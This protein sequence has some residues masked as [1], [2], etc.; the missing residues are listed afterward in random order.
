MDKPSGLP[1]DLWV[2]I[3]Q[4]LWALYVH[5]ADR[6]GAYGRQVMYEKSGN[7]AVRP[8]V[9]PSNYDTL[10]CLPMILAW[11]LFRTDGDDRHVQLL[12][13]RAV[14]HPVKE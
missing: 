7:E 5:L 8:K 14:N 4:T 12:E 3:E 13:E 1:Q 11:P 10:C 9:H 6:A 2:A